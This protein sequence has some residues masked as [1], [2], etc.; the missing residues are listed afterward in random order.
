[1]SIIDE[2]VDSPF[3]KAGMIVS[4]L[5]G[6]GLAVAGSVIAGRANKN[7]SEAT[8]RV[9]NEHYDAPLYEALEELGR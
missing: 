2:D 6:V 5:A 3:L 7:I 1:M 9:V 4:G 8:K